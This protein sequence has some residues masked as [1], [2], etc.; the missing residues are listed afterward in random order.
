MVSPYISFSNTRETRKLTFSE[1]QPS[2]KLV[3]V[4]G[5]VP[6]KLHVNYIHKIW[7]IVPSSASENFL[8][9]K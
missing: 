6:T 8:L 3:K 4:M 1:P 7:E 9:I 5:L 2:M